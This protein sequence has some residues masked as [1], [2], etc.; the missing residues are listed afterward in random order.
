[1]NRLLSFS[2]GNVPLTLFVPDA[3][4]LDFHLLFS[5]RHGLRKNENAESNNRQ[6]YQ[7]KDLFV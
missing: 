3:A 4:N 1:L 2:G 6:S 7:Q 5:C